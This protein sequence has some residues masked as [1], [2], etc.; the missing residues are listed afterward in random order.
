MDIEKS[1]WAIR[2]PRVWM[3]LIRMQIITDAT[4]TSRG[5]N[6]RCRLLQP[7][8]GALCS[9]D[10]RENQQGRM[11]LD[12]YSYHTGRPEAPSGARS[13]PPEAESDVVPC[14][15]ALFDV[16]LTAQERVLNGLH[17]AMTL[18][19]ELTSADQLVRIGV[20]QGPELTLVR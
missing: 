20:G 12:G 3:Q 5:R 18:D 6:Y 7:Q 1:D 13:N 10:G 11:K 15:L 4:H 17:A 16:Q 2:P 9:E 8:E 14:T 19:S